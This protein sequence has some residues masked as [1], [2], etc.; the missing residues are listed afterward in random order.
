MKIRCER[1]RATFGKES[2]FAVIV[3]RTSDG[4]VEGD[5]VRVVSLREGDVA[6]HVNGDQQCLRKVS[7]YQRTMSEKLRISEELNLDFLDT[8]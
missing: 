1:C 6:L 5:I 7:G 4:D 3:E 8:M 2:A